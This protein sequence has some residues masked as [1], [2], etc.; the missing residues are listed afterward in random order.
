MAK[1]DKRQDVISLSS[2]HPNP[3][4][5]R[6]IKDGKFAQLVDSIDRFD[7]MMR[8]RPMVVDENGVV[9]GGNMRLKALEQMGKTEIPKEWVIVADDLTEEEKLEFVIKDNVSYGQWDWDDLA[10]NWDT[11]SLDEWGLTTFKQ[12]DNVIDKVNDIENEEWI[13]MPDFEV[14]EDSHKVV[15]QFETEEDRQ[16]FQDQYQFKY[17][18]QGGTTWSLWWPYKD[19]DDL[20]SLKY[21]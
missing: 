8:L 1:S 4:N 11:V 12:D 21:E 7:K 20:Q 16:K 3:N 19:R 18:R 17:N 13:G 2:I 15:I 14:K 6:H 9:L 5:P 10:N